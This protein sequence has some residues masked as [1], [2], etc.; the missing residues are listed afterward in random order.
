M[1]ELGNENIELFKK[2]I[3]DH[4]EK[5]A[6]LM[7]NSS[8]E[9]INETI[10]GRVCF[11]NKLLEGSSRMLGLSDWSETLVILREFLE[12]I[13]NGGWTWDE[14]KSQ[15]ISEI[16]E[17][18][19]RITDSISSPDFEDNWNRT[20]FEGVKKE[21]ELLRVEYEQ[22]VQSTSIS[23]N[24]S[25]DKESVYI[26]PPHQMQSNKDDFNVFE[27]LTGL[28]EYLRNEFKSCIDNNDLLDQMTNEFEL[29]FEESKF[30][31][32]LV[33][34]IIN[35]I[36]GRRGHPSAEISSK[37]LI[38]GIRDVVKIYSQMKNRKIVFNT[39]SDEFLISGEAASAFAEI[40]SNCISDIISL[41]I[42]GEDD[43]TIKVDVTC[44]GS[45]LEVIVSDDCKRYLKGSEIDQDDPAAFYKGLLFVRDILRAWGGLL[46]V[47][48]GRSKDFRFK[49]TFP[50]DGDKTDYHVFKAMGKE[51]CIP[52]RCMEEAGEFDPDKNEIVFE[53]GRYYIDFNSKK[54]QV[55][56][57]RELVS[58]ENNSLDESSNII[59]VGSAE[60]RIGIFS[61]GPGYRFEG[62]KAQHV[63]ESWGS[64]SRYSLQIGDLS[65]FVLD[66]PMLFKRI[67]NLRSLETEF[68]GSVSG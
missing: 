33:G 40:I 5:L 38:D 18:E 23:N 53:D 47:E 36:T 61:N 2:Q 46:W 49:F 15:V 32:N 55:F 27:E 8:G 62:L 64:I 44:E 35:K 12:K 4:T 48:P 10:L 68:V 19:E 13:N 17:I 26:D 65:C 45:Y 31:M 41:Q 30:Y 3:G 1:P 54:I 59:I 14:N 39:N 52:L 6:L 34:S 66:V 56:G 63:E 11:A 37:H 29:K 16:I 51:I 9:L 7:D 67:E 60:E 58:E 42:D 28:F 22:D 25:S 21:I 20:V 43:L 57:M 50:T 24:G